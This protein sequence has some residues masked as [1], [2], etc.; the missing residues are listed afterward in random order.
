MRRKAAGT[1]REFPC[2]PHPFPPVVFL[3]AGGGID[4]AVGHAEFQFPD[5]GSNL[6]PLHWKRRVSTTGPPGKFSTTTSLPHQLLT[7]YKSVRHL[8]QLMNSIDVLLFGFL[9]FPLMLFF[10]PS[11]SYGP[12][13]PPVHLVIM[14]IRGQILRLTLCL[15]STAQVF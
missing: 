14:D 9:R 7:S 11:I 10:C 12:P 15:V 2:T 4:L 1:C 3:S 5:Q 8:S 6:R 13:V